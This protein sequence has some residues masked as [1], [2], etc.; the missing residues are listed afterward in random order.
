[1][2]HEAILVIGATGQQGGAVARELL[3]RGH[4]V[5]ALTRSP[6]SDPARALT[7][8]GATIVAGDL[9]DPASVRAAM[10]DVGGVFSVQTHMTP[11][12]VDGE[13][14]Q[15]KTVAE[16]AEQAG[17]AHLVYSSVDGAERA[18]GVPHFESKWQIE[19]YLQAL[20]L[21]ATVLRPT[22]FI[23][24]YA[25]VSRPQTVD[26]ELVVRLALSPTTPLQMLAVADIG[27][28]AADAFE[29]PDEY[30]GRAVALAGDELT[31]PQI[32]AVFAEHTGAPARFEEQPI[33]H[34][35]AFSDDY[36]RMFEWLNTHGYRADI[37]ALRRQHPGLRTL[38]SWLAETAWQ[39]AVAA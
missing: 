12:G 16:A 6:E 9:D 19:Q 22:G 17:I 20:G 29:R 33:E 23:D 2:G 13:V 31:G 10:A 21:P 26:G 8:K 1:M 18:S 35:R 32:A 28:F 37:P 15:G 24:N 36:A 38:R 25:T 7:A 11:A 27:V 5:Q 39:P 14:R 30:L 3:R 34:V 4:S